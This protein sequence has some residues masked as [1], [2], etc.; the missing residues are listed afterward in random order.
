MF[1]ILPIF[2]IFLLFQKYI[3]DGMT[4]GAVKG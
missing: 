4:A 3:I 2:V 1:G